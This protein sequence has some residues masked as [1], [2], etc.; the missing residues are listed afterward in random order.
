MLVIKRRLISRSYLV[1]SAFYRAGQKARSLGDVR[2]TLELKRQYPCLVLRTHGSEAASASSLQLR[3]MNL[4]G[5]AARQSQPAS[6]IQ[7]AQTTWAKSPALASVS[8]ISAATGSAQSN[9]S[10]RQSSSSVS[11]SGRYRNS[12][13]IK[14]SSASPDMS[15]AERSN[16]MARRQKN[17]RPRKST[18]F[19][20]SSK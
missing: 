3:S 19:Q 8:A 17:S 20:F 9:T 2:S 10:P 18:R 16:R 14:L 1:N 5:E 4:T 12:L 11:D 7:R 13:G 6:R 15:L